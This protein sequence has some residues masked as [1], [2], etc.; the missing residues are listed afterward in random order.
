MGQIFDQKDLI[1]KTITLAGISGATFC[2]RF[3]DGSYA[4]FRATNYDGTTEFDI[5][6]GSYSIEPNDLNLLELR[7]F[8][9]INGEEYNRLGNERRLR[10]MANQETYERDQLAKLK[11]KYEPKQ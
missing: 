1:G 11:K 2:L 8:G 6:E 4:I 9:V 5:E 7:D 10:Q 3:S